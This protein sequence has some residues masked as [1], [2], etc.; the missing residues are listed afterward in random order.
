MQY[1]E[2]ELTTQLWLCRCL[3]AVSFR[4][5]AHHMIPSLYCSVTSLGLRD[6]LYGIAKCFTR[7]IKKVM[8]G[9]E[10]LEKI[11]IK[12]AKQLINFNEMTVS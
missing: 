2:H 11:G 7:S 1:F 5:R 9:K 10:S 12:P 8:N 6:L 4:V 3:I